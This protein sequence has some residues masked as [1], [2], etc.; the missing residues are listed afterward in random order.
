MMRRWLVVVALAG[1]S[2]AFPASYKIYLVNGKVIQADDKP[3]IKDGIAYFQKAGL[4]L[5]LPA[6]Q[7]DLAKTERGPVPAVEAVEPATRRTA[8][9]QIGEEQLGEIS[10]RSRPANE[11]ELAQPILEGEGEAK[12]AAPGGS[13]AA[14][15][16]DRGALQNQIS[17]LLKQRAD[18][19]KRMLDLQSQLGGLRDRYSTTTSIDEKNAVQKQIESVQGQL[20]GTRSQISTVEGNLQDAQGQIA[21]SP[22]VIQAQ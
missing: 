2:L 11:G 4:E 18:L 5:Y 15:G 17:N 22:V 13:Q 14:G 21:N 10:R 3:F 9:R 16:V 1:L 7:V 8:V 12:P 19:Q 20:D 6:D